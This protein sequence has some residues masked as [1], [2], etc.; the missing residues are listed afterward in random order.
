MALAFHW[1]SSPY[2][3]R[4]PMLGVCTGHQ[5]MAQALW[6]VGWC[7]QRKEVMRGKASPVAHNGR[8]RVSGI[9]WP[10]TVTRYHSLVDPAV[11]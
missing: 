9:A 11:A 7:G 3:G 2:A 6:R 5:A 8:G 4:I 10:L 1:R